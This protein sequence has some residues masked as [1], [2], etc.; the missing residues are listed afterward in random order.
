MKSNQKKQY[1]TPDL[2]TY[3]TLEKLTQQFGSDMTD[4]PFGTGVAAAGPGGVTGPFS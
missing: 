3:G 1:V 4:V 2:T